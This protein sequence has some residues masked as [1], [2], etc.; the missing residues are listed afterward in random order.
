[1][2]ALMD[3][4]ALLYILTVLPTIQLKLSLT[5]FMQ[6]YLS[7][8]YCHMLDVIKEEKISKLD[9]IGLNIHRGVQEDEV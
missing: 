3:T 2:V 7:M 5:Y 9:F 1:M 6:L 4:H 8:G